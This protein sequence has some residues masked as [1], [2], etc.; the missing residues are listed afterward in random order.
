MTARKRPGP[1]A[2]ARKAANTPKETPE[3]ERYLAEHRA[4]NQR[5]RD[6]QREQVEPRYRDPKNGKL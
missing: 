5:W 1:K 3:M 2:R 4:E 6:R